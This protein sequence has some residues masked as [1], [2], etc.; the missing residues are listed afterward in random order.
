MKKIFALTLVL[1]LC[2]AIV[3]CNDDGITNNGDIVDLGDKGTSDN[4]TEASQ[5][6]DNGDGSTES[7]TTDPAD[8]VGD[9]DKT[10]DTTGS[11]TSGGQSDDKNWTQNY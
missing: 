11:Q 5:T 10:D 6:Q 3:A 9:T 8:T 7:N 4:K 1:L 2:F